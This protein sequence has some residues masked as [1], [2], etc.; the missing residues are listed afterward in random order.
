MLSPVLSGE[1]SYEDIMTHDDGGYDSKGITLHKGERES[2]L[3][4]INK[5]VTTEN[6]ITAPYDKLVVATGS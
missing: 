5:T 3:D 2:E 1:K 6:E 4:K